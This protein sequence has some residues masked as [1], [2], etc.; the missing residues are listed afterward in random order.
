VT[1]CMEGLIA[2]TTLCSFRGWLHGALPVTAPGN[3]WQLPG[4][5]IGYER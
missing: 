4:V 5:I 2:Q 3:C 1:D